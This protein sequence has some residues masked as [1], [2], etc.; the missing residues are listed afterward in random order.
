MALDPTTGAVLAEVSTAEL[1]PQPAEHPRHQRGRRR[2]QEAGQADPAKPLLNRAVQ[3]IYPPGS[4]F[5]VITSAAAL[6]ADS[7]LTPRLGRAGRRVLPAAADLV[8]PIKNAHEG[9]CPEQITL[10]QALTVSCNTVFARMGVEQIGADKLKS[11]AQAFGFEARSRGSSRTRTRT[12]ATSR[13]A[14]PAR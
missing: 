5:K 2:L 11:M 12:T 10:K 1:R 14:T 13:P 7:S 4:T 3:E 9:I 6:S 8:V